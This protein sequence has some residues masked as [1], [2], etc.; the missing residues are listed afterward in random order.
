[1]GTQ[2]AGRDLFSG[3]LGYF[4]F[5]PDRAA[6]ERRES[7]GAIQQKRAFS[8]KMPL[9]QKQSFRLFLKFT[10]KRAGACLRRQRTLPL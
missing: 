4:K 7:F 10:P 9:F 6:L 5:K 8:A 1:M 3:F 2:S